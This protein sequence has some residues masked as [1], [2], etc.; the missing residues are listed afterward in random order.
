MKGNVRRIISA[1]T[2]LSSLIAIF[3]VLIAIMGAVV[4][5]SHNLWLTHSQLQSLLPAR[6][7]FRTSCSSWIALNSLVK[8]PPKFI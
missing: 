2:L 5:A 7:L 1:A 3:L 4:L 8:L 6:S